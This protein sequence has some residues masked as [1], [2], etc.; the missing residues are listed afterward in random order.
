MKYKT[1][2]EEFW[3]GSFGNDYIKRNFD[4]KLIAGN[5]NIFSQILSYTYEVE[6]VLEFGANIGLNLVAMKQLLPQAS[7]SAVEINKHACKQLSKHSWVNVLNKSILEYKAKIKHNFVLTKGFLIHIN[8]EELQNVYKTLYNSSSKYICL[9]EYYNPAPVE[10]N[11]RGFSNK[12]FKRD[13]AGELMK[14]YP[15][16]KLVKYGFVYHLDPNFPMDDLN[17]FLLEKK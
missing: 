14:K 16:L 1:E 3:S 4:E 5:V 13:F 7:F 11:Y 17:W 8:P 9:V 6:S 15:S 2:Q 12:L 10:I